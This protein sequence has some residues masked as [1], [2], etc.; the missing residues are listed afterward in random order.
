LKQLVLPLDFPPA[1]EEKDFVVSTANEDAYLWVMRW[2]NWPSRCLAIYGDEGCGKTHLS[3]LWQGVTQA[4]RLTGANFNETPLATLL[5]G[6]PFF[7]LDEAS[8]IE[9]GEKLFHLYNHL[10]HEQGGALLLSKTPPAHW[11]TDLPDLRS[12]LNAIPAVKIHAPDEILLAKVIQKLFADLQIKVEDPIIHFLLNHMERSF[13]SARLWVHTLNMHAL[14]Q[15]RSITIPL[16]REILSA[17]G[18]G[19]KNL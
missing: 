2:P 19:E 10:N 16:V 13:E 14:T 17:Q 12:R 11:T 6:P 15:K 7:V 5:D 4:R 1:F 9:T 3:H 8:L 18:L